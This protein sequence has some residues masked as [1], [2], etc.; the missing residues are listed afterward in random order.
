MKNDTNIAKE[1]HG[2]ALKIKQDANKIIL[3]Q[4]LGRLFDSLTLFDRNNFPN[5]EMGRCG[6]HRQGKNKNCE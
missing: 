1:W 6:G 5:T 4:S 2:H 3:A